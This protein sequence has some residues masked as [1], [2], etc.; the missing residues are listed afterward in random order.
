MWVA[1]VDCFQHWIYE[2][3]S[4]TAFER[5]KEWI[6]IRKRFGADLI[7]WRGLNEEHEYLWHRQLHIFEVPFYYIEYGIAQLGAL[8]IWLNAKKN[9]SKAL[10]LY[11]DGL[12]LG[13]SKSLPELFVA[14]GIRFDF[15]RQTIEPL[16]DEVCREIKL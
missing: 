14:A 5:A 13:G 16:M 6:N 2:N 9:W 11:Q 8:Q 3:P 7:D 1:T 12:S 4:H 15:S 10:K